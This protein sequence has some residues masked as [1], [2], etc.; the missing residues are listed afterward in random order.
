MTNAASSSMN[1]FAK[2]SPNGVIP[3]TEFGVEIPR[4][5]FGLGSW[6]NLIV[7]IYDLLLIFGLHCKVVVFVTCFA[8]I[9][10]VM[11]KFNVN[12]PCNLEA[13]YKFFII[14]Y[15]YLILISKLN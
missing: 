11:E 2:E 15:Y 8:S 6:A 12:S 13:M 5:M 4:F 7:I 14:L 9:D 10:G 1:Y 3:N